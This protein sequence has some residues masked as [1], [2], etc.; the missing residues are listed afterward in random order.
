[1]CLRIFAD[2]TYT[3]TIRDAGLFRDAGR[4]NGDGG[5]CTRAGIGWC[6]L[7]V[8]AFLGHIAHL[9]RA[10][11]GLW[12]TH[13]LAPHLLHLPRHGCPHTAHV[14]PMLLVPC[15]VHVSDNHIAVDDS[16]SVISSVLV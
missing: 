13:N 5:V 4:A 6:R 2:G 3:G 11:F 15:F 14:A 8:V 12:R 16:V 9:P 10:V 1:M 7:S